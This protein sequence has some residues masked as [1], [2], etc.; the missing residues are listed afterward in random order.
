MSV[1]NFCAGPA[2]LPKEVMKKAQ[3]EFVNWQ[4]VGVSVMEM[5]HR[6]R[7]FIDL[8][9]QSEQ[10]LRELMKISDDYAVLFM[11]GGG[12]G[13]FSA[14]PLNLHQNNQSAVYINTGIWSDGA[15]TEAKKFTD[16]IALNVR[17]DTANAFN[18]V[19]PKD[20]MLPP[21][22]AYI[23][24]CSNETIDGIELFDV[25]KH[26][27]PVVVDM[28]SN[29]LSKTMQVEDYDVIYAGA[30]KNIGPSGLAI[31]IIKKSLL[32]REGLPKPSILDYALEAKKESMYNTPPTFSWYLAAEVFKWLKAQGGV[33]AIEQH[34]IE[35]AK[36]LYEYIDNSAFYHN[37]VNPAVRSRMNVPF[38]LK[39]EAFNQAFL[40]QSEQAG[41]L[42]LEGHRMVGGMRASIYNAMPTQGIDALISFMHKFEKEHA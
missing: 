42:A 19:S 20:W 36:K 24:Y 8:A 10:D 34:N 28:S 22:A 21:D 37:K 9:Q 40:A 12:R 3:Q 4:N 1:Y 7:A 15:F 29:I 25:P 14:V 5:S 27:A 32:E 39:N 2:G 26:N 6:S 33:S 16:A 18:V 30:Q 23:H 17:Q 35:K 11:H 13:Q 38:W 31:V 41:L